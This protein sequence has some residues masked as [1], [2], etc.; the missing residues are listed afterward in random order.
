[1][2]DKQLQLQK[3]RE[4]RHRNAEN[5]AK[6]AKRLMREKGVTQQDLVNGGY[7]TRTAINRLCRNSNDKGG[8]YKI[9]HKD[10][11]DLAFG[12]GLNTDEFWKLFF[13]AFPE[14]EIGIEGIEKGMSLAEVNIRLYD[15]NKPTFGITEQ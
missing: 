14:V 13:I 4:Y 2:T 7:F 15:E 6:A 8:D 9:K 1:M 11:F 3:Q 12:L 5:F 10:I